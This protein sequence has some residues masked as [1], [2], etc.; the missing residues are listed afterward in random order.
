MRVARVFS[1]KSALVVLS[2]GVF[3]LA[4]G[5]CSIDA[6]Y[7][8]SEKA[9]VLNKIEA[10]ELELG[11]DPFSAAQNNGS[12]ARR[13]LVALTVYDEGMGDVDGRGAVIVID[14]LDESSKLVV[15]PRALKEPVTIEAK[16][17]QFATPWGPVWFYDFSPDGL[18]FLRPARLYLNTEMPRGEPLKLFWFNPETGKWQLEQVATTDNSGKV[19]FLINHFSKYAIS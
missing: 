16:T 13:G 4:L 12:L 6:P 1:W 2:L 17:A 10:V 7:A 8:P 19:V 18:Q 14:Q 9:S 3:G 5:G 11:P 15:P